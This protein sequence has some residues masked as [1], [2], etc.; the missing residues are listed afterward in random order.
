MGAAISTWREEL[1]FLGSD[2][3]ESALAAA[4][5]KGLWLA[6]DGTPGPLA[7]MCCGLGSTW[8]HMGRELY[9][10]FPVCRNAM[11]E[12]ATLADWDILSLMDEADADIINQ[13]RKQ[14]PYLFLLEFAQ[15]R[16]FTALGLAPAL[17]SGHSLGELIGLCL[18]GALPL[19]AAWHLLDTRASHMNALEEKS[20]NNSGMLA[21]SAEWPVIENVLA[22]Y[23]EVKIAN[24][25]TPRQY[26]LGGPR[27]SLLEARKN[28]RRQRIPAIMLNMGIAFHHPGMRILR[29]MSLRRLS[30]LSFQ[31]PPIPMFS[32]VTAS[33]YP[34]DIPGL[35]NQMTDLDENTVDWPASLK[36]MTGN[37]GIATF[38]ELGPQSTLQSLTREN[39]PAAVCISTNRKGHE[40]ESMRQAIARLFSLGYLPK[41]LTSPAPGQPLAPR[42]AVDTQED[43]QKEDLSPEASEIIRIIAEASGLSADA[44]RLDMDL[45]RDL[46]LRSSRFPGLL[47]AAEQRLGREIELEN[48][49]DVTTVGDLARLFLQDQPLRKSRDIHKNPASPFGSLPMFFKEGPWIRYVWKPGDVQPDPAPLDPQNIGW[50][51]KPGDIIPVFSADD[52]IFKEICAALAP[53]DITPAVPEELLSSLPLDLRKKA[54]PLLC[55]GWPD[56]ET[57]TKTLNGLAGKHEA[58]DEV[59]FIPPLDSPEAFA[60]PENM[61]RVAILQRFTAAN[62]NQAKSAWQMARNAMK[63]LESAPQARFIALLDAPVNPLDPNLRPDNLAAELLTGN[64]KNALWINSGIKTDWRQPPGRFQKASAAFT[65]IWPASEAAPGPG[66]FLG[67][68]QFSTFANPALA[69]HTNINASAH[70]PHGQLLNPLALAANPL[71]PGMKLQCLADVS[72]FQQPGIEPG[73]TRECRIEAKA[74]QIL[75]QEGQ[76]VRLCPANLSC[77]AIRPNGR[78]KNSWLPVVS[79][80]LVYSGCQVPLRPVWKN[81]PKTPSTGSDHEKFYAECQIPETWRLLESLSASPGD[82]DNAFQARFIYKDTVIAGIKDWEYKNLFHTLDCVIQA[83]HAIAWSQTGENWRLADI[84]YIRFAPENVSRQPAGLICRLAITWRS[85]AIFR[86]DAQVENGNLL[87]TVNH[88][89]FVPGKTIIN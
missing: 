89:E 75:S 37:Y 73:L 77:R 48:L 15:W 35:L 64:A 7:V 36:A 23:P 54:I 5:E 20:A 14:I 49:L 88:L 74:G 55:P 10:N 63:N 61:L 79:S 47:Q 57:V 28:L 70:I 29:D 78:A 82:G 62:E 19:D 11:D 8:P 85:A 59:I 44:V 72:F 41:A 50:P 2:P 86:F 34:G 51:L 21:I 31:A 26:V 53:R 67:E 69:Q 71:F 66:I 25:N 56:R 38:L 9:D 13:T 22:K 6:P 17:M 32:S 42:K 3:E 65:T 83:A 84:G 46:A 87:M 43:A 58:I 27:S 80:T 12:V 45:R 16:Q 30:A 68:C 33:L 24:I 18:T 60:P 52:F 81:P 40:A 1:A 4:A 39:L 76:S